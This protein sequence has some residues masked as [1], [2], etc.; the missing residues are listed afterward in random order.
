MDHAKSSNS[1][2]PEVRRSGKPSTGISPEFS[3]LNPILVDAR[4]PSDALAAPQKPEGPA[5]SRGRSREN[6]DK[7]MRTAGGKI[8]LASLNER[9]HSSG[10]EIKG[11]SKIGGSETNYANDGHANS[12][13]MVFGLMTSWGNAFGFVVLTIFVSVVLYFAVKRF[14][15]RNRGHQDWPG[16]DQKSIGKGDALTNKTGHFGY[17]DEDMSNN[18]K[19]AD[20]ASVAKG[21]ESENSE[22]LSVATTCASE[23]G[24]LVGREEVV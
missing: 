2:L 11:Y 9:A 21:L 5:G 18:K 7:I 19:N 1:G 13:F 12:M 17:Y 15:S 22:D 3:T 8:R 10:L 23:H 14:L 20:W 24:N 16:M 4:S 6:Y